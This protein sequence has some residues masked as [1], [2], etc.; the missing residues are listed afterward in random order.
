MENLKK[1]DWMS[2]NH[3]YANFMLLLQCRYG[4]IFIILIYYYT[5]PILFFKFLSIPTFF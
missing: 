4:I 5:H 3:T 1:Q 2:N